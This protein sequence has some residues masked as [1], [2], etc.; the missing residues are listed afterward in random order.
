MATS[1]RFLTAVHVL[2]LLADHPGEAVTSEYVAGSVNTNPVVVR[3]ILRLL[4]EAGLVSSTEGAGGGTKLVRPAER[5]TLADVYRAVE[6]GEL[7]GATRNPPNPRCPVGRSVQAVL[8]EHLARFEA[9]LE[10]EMDKVT[11]ADMWSGCVG[12]GKATT[13]QKED[14]KGLKK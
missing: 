2:T 3:R 9:S 12:G 6:P 10:R 4:K 14:R 11:I 7:F 1:S 8:Q 13:N 5:I